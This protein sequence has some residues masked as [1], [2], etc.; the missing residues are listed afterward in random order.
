MYYD[1]DYIP[2]EPISEK[3]RRK[4]FFL[5]R[6]KRF[7][8]G[9]DDII[10][11]VITQFYPNLSAKEICVCKLIV[12]DSYHFGYTPVWR[13]QSVAQKDYKIIK[14]EWEVKNVI[15]SLCMR[16]IINWMTLL[17][18]EKSESGKILR[19]RGREIYSV[20]PV[21]LQDMAREAYYQILRIRK[22]IETPAIRG[23]FEIEYKYFIIRPKTDREDIPIV[24]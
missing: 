16:Q 7:R 3:L 6:S 10:P 14:A 8:N 12:E 21:A 23:T 4:I 18:P 13:I 11:E 1:E 20:N 15:L 17:I 19:F 24:N 5:A 9:Y 2:I 22:I